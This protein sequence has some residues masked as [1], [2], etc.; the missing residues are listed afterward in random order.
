MRKATLWPALRIAGIYAVVSAL[1]IV[2]S[3]RL[4]AKIVPHAETVTSI[5]TYNLDFA[6]SFPGGDSRG[7]RLNP[8][9]I[10]SGLWHGELSWWHAVG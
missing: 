10:C 8:R 6:S 7:G 2:G 1:Y 4:L 3:D 5:Q 9:F